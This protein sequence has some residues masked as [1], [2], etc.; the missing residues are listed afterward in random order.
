MSTADTDE[1]PEGWAWAKVGDVTETVPNI[2]PVEQPKRAFAYA[3]ISSIDNQ[4]NRITAT[5]PVLGKDAP[6]RARRPVR[7]DD[8]LFSNVRTYLR[9]VAIVP[10][11]I[12]A[13]VCSTGFTVLRANAAVDARYLFRYALTDEFVRL[14]DE[15]STGTHYP[16]TSDRAVMALPLPLP[17]LAE[18]RRIVA[19]VEAV[20]AQVNAARDRLNRVPAILKRFRQSVLAAACS[21]R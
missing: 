12:S 7:P 19:A 13:D 15:T 11:D 10:R 1:L 4:T 17:P 21:G 18:Q 14:T 20:L 9:N 8:V 3:D 16:A 5:R 6:S 2:K